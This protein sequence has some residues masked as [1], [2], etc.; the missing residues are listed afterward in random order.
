MNKAFATFLATF[1]L[2]GF[3]PFAPGTAASLVVVVLVWLTSL[4]TGPISGWSLLVAALGIYFVGIPAATLTERELGQKDP[5]PIVIDEVAG[6]LVALAFLPLTWQT[7]LMAF[8]L[9]RIFD[10]IKPFPINWLDKN[11]PGGFG[12]MSDDMLAGA[13]ALGVGH[14]V[15]RFVLS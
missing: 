4:L 13:F 15:L 10:I 1:G 7:M 14:L 11:L 5:R 8:L 6:Q 12:I 3:F 2:I 9:F